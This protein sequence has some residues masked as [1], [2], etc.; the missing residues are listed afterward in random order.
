[1][2]ICIIC[3]YAKNVKHCTI[4][5]T[6]YVFKSMFMYLV[7]MLL[8]QAVKMEKAGLEEKNLSILIFIYCMPIH[9]SVDTI[10]LQKQN[11][12]FLGCVLF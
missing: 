9:T 4:D 10:P 1:M 12:H 5:C 3:T 6:L 11:K 2:N 8:K 7:N